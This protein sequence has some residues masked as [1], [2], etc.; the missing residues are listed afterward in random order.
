MHAHTFE[1]ILW[2][3]KANTCQRCY[4]A[5][6]EEKDVAPGPIAQDLRCHFDHLGRVL[7]EESSRL[8]RGGSFHD[9]R[10][11]RFGRPRLVLDWQRGNASIALTAGC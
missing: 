5:Y 2:Q 6:P 1:R 8:F 11:D 9:G 7:A 10:R 4:C 3:E